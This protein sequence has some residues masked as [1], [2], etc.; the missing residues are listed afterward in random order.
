MDCVAVTRATITPFGQ[1]YGWPR[2]LHLEAGDR[3]EGQWKIAVRDLEIPLAID[4]NGDRRVTWGEVRVRSDEIAT[5]ALEHLTVRNGQGT[6]QGSTGEILFERLGGTAYLVLPFA[7][8]CPPNTS[9][10]SLRYDLFFDQ[11]PTHRGLLRL[12]DDGST[13]SAI[14]AAESRSLDLQPSRAAGWARQF[15]DYLVEGIWHIWI[16]YDHIVF[17]VALLLPA[18]YQRREGQWRPQATFRPVVLDVTAI[19]TAFTLAHSLS[20]SAAALGLLALPSVLVETVI[21]LSVTIAAI[22]VIV[23][24]LHQRRW[25]LGFGFGLIH[26]FG[27]AG[28]LNDLGL[29]AGARVISLLAFN[30]GVEIGQLAIVAVVLPA[31][32]LMRTAPI[33]RRA[34]VPGTASVLALAGA[35]W[36]FER[37]GSAIG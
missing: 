20:L 28:V 27:F 10:R 4:A 3:L 21:A 19:V 11:D 5:Y 13:R 23:P 22:N 1:R 17:L 32:Y 26:G 6:C 37:M 36:A 29:P 25:L 34:A 15:G 7:F 14:F 35:Y 24:V 12:T 16:G 30:I 18:V 8:H 2:D 9:A 33:Y 31:M